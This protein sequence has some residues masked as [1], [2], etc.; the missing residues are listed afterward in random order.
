MA[1]ILLINP[2][3]WGR[4]ITPIWIASHSAVLKSKGHIVKLFDCTFY[5]NWTINEMKYNTEN[6]QYKSSNYFDYVNFNN[7]DIVE[8]LQENIDEY[9]PDVIFWSAFSSHIHGEGEYVNIQYGYQLIKK[10]KTSAILVTGGLQ[11]TADPELMYKNFPDVNYFI[12]GETEFALAELV[13]KYPNHDNIKSKVNGLIFKENGTIKRNPRQNLIRDM[14]IIPMYDYSLFEDQV[15]YR[16]YN[17]KVIKG[18]DFE[19]SRGCPYTCS[20]CVETVMQKYYGFDEIVGNGVARNAKQYLR[21]KSGKRVFGEMKYLYENYSIKY[22]RCQDT[23]FLTIDRKTLET[24]ANLLDS[25]D[26]PIMLYI[27]T[28]PESIKPNII[29]LMKKLKIDGVGMGIELAS[30]KF[31]KTSLNRYPSQEKI[32]NAFKIL[33]ESG[34]NRTTYN[35]IGLPD[36]TEEMILETIKFNQELEPDNITVAFYS[37]YLGTPEQVKSKELQY[38]DDYEYHVDGQ[39]RTVSRSVLVDTKILNFYKKYFVELVKNGLDKL[40]DLKKQDG[41]NNQY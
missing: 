13:N 22:F 38:F 24:L 37:P 39:I 28:R 8:S 14:D 10:I 4:G 6:K 30:E 20:Y 33:R 9:K 34:I 35:I 2:N 1:K 7:K 26:L 27:E 18:V 15:F 16:S 25:N 19:L 31:R 12:G 36:E 29:P 5:Q 23:N 3:K 40:D 17:G 41:L 11:V 21:N 32:I